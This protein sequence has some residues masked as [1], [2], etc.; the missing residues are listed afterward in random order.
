MPP[1]IPHIIED[2]IEKKRCSHCKNYLPLN[3]FIYK[4][5]RWDRL[6]NECNKCKTTR[7]KRRYNPDYIYEEDQN[8]QGDNN[9]GQEE[10]NQE[11]N[12]NN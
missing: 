8:N 4:K 9:N 7:N 3:E 5:D 6:N 2:G 10:N 1:R 12:E 11:E